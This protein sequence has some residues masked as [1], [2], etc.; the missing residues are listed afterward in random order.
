LRAEPTTT[1][2]PVLALLLYPLTLIVMSVAM[3]SVLLERYM[4]P[5][6]IPLSPVTAL[7]ALPLNRRWGRLTAGVAAA[8]MLLVGCLELNLLRRVTRW[9][10]ETAALVIDIVQRAFGA[11]QP[12]VFARRFEA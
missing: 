7:T 6:V 4:I 3:Q 5:V 9:D 8:S 12:G 1:P 11:R 10:G 2:F